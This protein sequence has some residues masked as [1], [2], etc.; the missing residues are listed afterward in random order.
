M[1]IL[2]KLRDTGG[3]NLAK[4][5]QE[6]GLARS[7]VH[8][9]VST[10]ESEKLVSTASPDGRIQLGI[11]LISL[12]AAVNSDLRRELH[13]YLEGLSIEVDETVDLAVLDDDRLLFLDQIARPR[14]LRAVSGVGMSFPLHCSANGKAYLA[15]MTVEQVEVLIPEHLQTFTP[16]TLSTRHDLLRELEQI[17][18]AGGIAFDREEHTQGICAVGSM[19]R[20]PLGQ[21]AVISIPVPSV[22]FAGNEDTFATS[23]RRTVDQINLRFSYGDL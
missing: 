1:A 16:N 12:G 5:A 9:I 20:G 8:R 10:L 21:V 6:V 22:R 19:V 13:P 14:R 7:T 17:R 2:R 3:L 23:L 4:L 18:A 11:E 15:T